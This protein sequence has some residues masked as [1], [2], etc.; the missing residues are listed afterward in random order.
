[1]HRN[2]SE[3]V[4]QGFL[5]AFGGEPEG[6]WSAPGRVSLMGDHTDLEDGIT[7][8]FTYEAR[9]AVAIA[10]R[11]D[12]EIRIRTDLD[13]VGVDAALDELE[14]PGAHS[15]RDYP[16][17]VIRALRD[18][19]ADH[20]PVDLEPAKRATGLDVF[21]TTDV[22]IGGGLASSASLCAALTTA[23]NELWELEQSPYRLARF[24]HEVENGYIGASAGMSDHVT[25]HFGGPEHDVF[26]DARGGDVSLIDE[27]DLAA[28]GFVPLLIES[29]ETHRNWA[30]TV[31]D[32]H[33]ACKAVADELGLNALR[34]CDVD[35]L[36]AARDRLD[37][38]AYRR[39]R[40]IVTET[41]RVLDFTRLLR[42]EGPAAVGRL[43]TESQRS[44]RDDFEVSTER[45]DAICDT[46]LAAGAEGAR[47]TGSGFGGCVF[48]LVPTERVDA[49]RESL[50]AAYAER[51]WDG[52]EIYEAH[53]SPG[54]RRD[55]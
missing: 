25:V 46:A 3:V 36:E 26:Y 29:G 52:L 8:G 30:G 55:V 23:L 38:V 10:R 14:H 35:E 28:A 11:D 42:T 16:V 19:I 37:A 50:A 4:R 13:E 41:Q 17:G 33:A 2:T 49:V 40:Y 31:N 47:M 48:A 18:W 9:S 45:V 24:G 22:P 53:S 20:P 34:E 27:P 32:R 21:I 12:R 43:F 39:A 6:V 54:T 5:A 7:Y 51:G 15:W 1:M 44:L